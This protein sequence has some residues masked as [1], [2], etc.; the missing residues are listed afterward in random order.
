MAGGGPAKIMQNKMLDIQAQ[1]FDGL[2]ERAFRDRPIVAPDARE[3]EISDW[4]SCPEVR[5]AWRQPDAGDTPDGRGPCSHSRGGNRPSR[6]VEVEFGP[7]G[8]DEV[9]FPHHR[10]HEQVQSQFQ[11][12]R[13]FDA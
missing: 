7:G 5:A 10:Q 12:R 3:D 1:R 9:G 11:R 13:M 6:C 8:L 2:I 4:S